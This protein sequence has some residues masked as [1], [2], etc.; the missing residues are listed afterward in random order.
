[1]R[2]AWLCLLVAA[3][4]H[5]AGNGGDGGTADLSTGDGL[6]GGADAGVPSGV[7]MVSACTSVGVGAEPCSYTWLFDPAACA[8][9]ACKRLVI[10]FSG[11]QETCPDPAS[12]TSFLAYYKNHGY[13]A[14]CAMDFQ[15]ATGSAQYPR[16]VEAQK[17]DPLVKAITSDPDILSAWS[18]EFLLFSG[19]SHGASTPVV[20]MATQTY[21]SQPSWQGSKLTGAC[22]NDGTYDAGGLLGFCFTNQCVPG[23]SVVPYQ[24]QYSR[25]CNWPST[26]SGAMPATW[27]APSTCMNADVAA[28]TLTNVDVTQFAIHDWKLTECGSALDPCSKDVLPAPPIAALCDRIGAQ[29]GYTCEKGSFPNIG[30]ILCGIEATSIGS[31]DTWF[32]GKL[33]AHGF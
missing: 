6:G 22:F 20:A 15:S 10:Y 12:T 29:P 24:R 4:G 31:C 32:T 9:R 19:V 27:P 3:C 16:H 8:G 18:G 5:G 28:D 30:H 25:Y 21:D 17:A 1:M 23:T 14:V 11:G 2:L 33:A 26:A 13:V 7:R